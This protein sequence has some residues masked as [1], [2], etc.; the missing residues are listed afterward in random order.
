MNRRLPSDLPIDNPNID[1]WAPIKYIT[2]VNS[3]YIYQIGEKKYFFFGDQH[4]SKSAGGCQE[5][6]NLKCDDYDSNFIDGKYYGSSCTSI[7]ILLLRAA[8]WINFI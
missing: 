8:I 3:L 1:S 5:Q 2:D 7:G 6:L 4:K